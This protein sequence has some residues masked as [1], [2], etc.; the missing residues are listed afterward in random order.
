ML[1]V[2]GLMLS[3]LLLV[4]PSLVLWGCSLGLFFGA[5]LSDW[6]VPDTTL[7]INSWNW[8]PSVFSDCT[9]TGLWHY[10][11]TCVWWFCCFTWLTWALSS[12][13]LLRL[14]QSPSSQV[15]GYIIYIYLICHLLLNKLL[16][17]I[18]TMSTVLTYSTFSRYGIGPFIK[19]II[20]HVEFRRIK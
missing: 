19:K 5:V 2:P 9:D 7:R 6:T 15:C 10:Q 11:C 17:V 16:L 3:V 14:P 4:N 18:I 8:M 1:T 20:S 12:S 13:T